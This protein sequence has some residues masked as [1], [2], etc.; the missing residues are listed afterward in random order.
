MIEFDAHHVSVFNEETPHMGAGEKR[1]VRMFRDRFEVGVPGVEA[2][3]VAD[4][5]LHP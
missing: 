5:E 2:F 1:Q 4:V 3:P